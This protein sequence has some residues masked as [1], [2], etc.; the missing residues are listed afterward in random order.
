[1]NGKFY[2]GFVSTPVHFFGKMS[3]KIGN[4]YQVAVDEARRYPLMKFA[5][6]RR[7]GLSARRREEE[8]GELHRCQ[9]R[10]SS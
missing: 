8:G 6:K 9:S 4:L 5:L 10:V 7:S 2:G 1:M 3:I